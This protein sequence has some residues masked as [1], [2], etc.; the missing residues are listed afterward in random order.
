MAWTRFVPHMQ[1]SF[2]PPLPALSS[3]FIAAEMP[4]TS[5]VYQE[6]THAKANQNYAFCQGQSF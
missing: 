4:Y 2:G 5:P 3:V 6:K 1:E